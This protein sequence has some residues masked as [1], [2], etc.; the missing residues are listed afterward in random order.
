MPTIT[1]TVA[2]VAAAPA[3]QARPAALVEAAPE[4]VHYLPIATTA[5]SIAFLITLV[6]RA[7]KRKWAPHLTWWAIGVFTYGVG[8]ALESSITLFGN[9]A[10]LT[11]SWYIAGALLGGYPLGTGSAYLLLKRNVAHLLTAITMLVV[12]FATV[13][14]I[15]SPIN[16]AALEPH[17]PTGAAIG[18][19]WI[20]AITPFINGYAALFLVGGAAWSA[21]RFASSGHNPKRALGTAFIAVGGLLP[22]IGGGYAKA[23]F[24]EALYVGE[25]VGLIFIW[26]GYEI[27]LRAP[28]PIPAKKAEPAHAEGR[29]EHA[30]APEPLLRNA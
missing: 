13:A 15:L 14:V 22:G 10:D 2:A 12:I 29:A 3:A 1:Q 4:L 6:A 9:T 20:R 23:G 16:A 28:A 26:I 7:S 5:I 30:H 18:W 19:Q 8:T 11:R 17:R 21:I 25:F 27:C 24:V